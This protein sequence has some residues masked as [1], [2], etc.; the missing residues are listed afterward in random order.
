MP[1]IGKQLPSSAPIEYTPSV[2][3]RSE[4]WYVR[5]TI[6]VSN[7]QWGVLIQENFGSDSPGRKRRYD[8]FQNLMPDTKSAEREAETTPQQE[9]PIFSHE[10]DRVLVDSPFAL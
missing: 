6:G 1:K 10:K 3:T 7:P 5:Y 4:V 2:W 8:A 9:Y